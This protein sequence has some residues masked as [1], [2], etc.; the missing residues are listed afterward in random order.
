MRLVPRMLAVAVGVAAVSVHAAAGSS[1]SECSPLQLR[2]APG[3][4]E[5]TGQHSAT[6]VVT[7]GS[8]ARCTFDGYPRV[9]LLDAHGRVLHFR[10]HR[11]GDQMITSRPP[12][13]V[14]VTRGGHVYFAVNK[15]RCDVRATARAAAI[16]AGLPGSSTWHRL[17]LPAHSALD[18]CGA[19]APSGIVSVSPVVSSLRDAAAG[20]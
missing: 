5:K 7:N 14:V 17:A 15:Y 16:R 10:Y 11:G 2:A 6:F 13:R 8:G 1:R 18:F 20:S 9:V 3:W 12:R 4:S 19:A